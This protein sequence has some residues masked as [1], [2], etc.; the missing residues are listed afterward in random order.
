M[1]VFYLKELTLRAFS[2]FCTFTICKAT[3]NIKLLP[4]CIIYNGFVREQNKKINKIK[5]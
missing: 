1:Y 3:Q 5:D 4:F 2:P